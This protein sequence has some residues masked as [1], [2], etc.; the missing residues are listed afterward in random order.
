MNVADRLPLFRF[1]SAWLFR[2]SWLYLLLPWVLFLWGWLRPWV[3]V[4]GIFLSVL[5]LWHLWKHNPDFSPILLT[6]SVWA[7]LFLLGLWVFLSGIGGYAFQNWDHHWR[8]AVFHDLIDYSWPV[9]Y[10]SGGKGPVQMLVYYMGYWL[11]AALIG[12]RLG[13]RVA[14]LVLFL[15]TWLGVSLVGLHLSLRLRW[16]LWRVVLL[17][18]FFSGAD[19]IGTLLLPKGSYPSLWPPIQ[20]LETWGE[21]LQYS[22][23]T[24]NLFWV[25]NQ[26]VPAWLCTILLINR[27]PPD[28]VFLGWALAFFFAPLPALG[29]LPFAI[30]EWLERARSSGSPLFQ[31]LFQAFSLPNVLAASI[32]LIAFLYFSA[33]TALQ[34]RSWQNI[35]LAKLLLFL[36]LEGGLLWMTLVWNHYRDLRW[37]LLGMMLL[38]FPFIQV[39]SGRDFVMRA[40]IPAL[41]YLMVWTAEALFSAHFPRLLRGF[42]FLLLGIGA[43]TPLYEINRSI[44]RTFVYYA[45]PQESERVTPDPQPILHLRLDTA[46]EADHPGTLVADRIRSLANVQD[47]LSKNYVA[48]VRRSFFYRFLAKH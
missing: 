11:P 28:Q 25:F 38:L 39:G 26:A 1:Q 7:G 10:A 46:P 31:A 41:F 48:N 15:W 30:L 13:W 44:Y 3:A 5:A 27:I 22:S 4:I 8:N 6:R 42:L 17:L 34:S 18:V 40:S 9:Y 36:G 29:L 16:P 32:A 23:F 45:T 20:H 24:T 37:Y 2:L 19:A 47:K 14:N 21:N 33:N 35:P 12:K 43:L